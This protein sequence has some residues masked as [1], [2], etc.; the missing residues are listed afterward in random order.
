MR[1]C[2]PADIRLNHAQVAEFFRLANS[3]TLQELNRRHDFAPCQLE[4]TLRRG[5][6]VCTWKIQ[7]SAMGEMTCEGKTTYFV[8]NSANCRRLFP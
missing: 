4:G 8:C 5:Q 2:R 6:T 7:A 1:I 3:I